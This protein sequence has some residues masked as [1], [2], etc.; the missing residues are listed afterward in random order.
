[1]PE[2]VVC[3]IR[4]AGVEPGLHQSP[5]LPLRQPVGERGNVVVRVVVAECRASSVK[6]VL[7]VDE[8]HCA[9]DRGLERAQ[10]GAGRKE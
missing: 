2:Q 5:A 8:D 1:M 3:A 9:L 6:Q 7:A 4:H 10:C